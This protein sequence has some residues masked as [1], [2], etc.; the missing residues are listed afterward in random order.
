MGL[1]LGDM[2]AWARERLATVEDGAPLPS[3]DASLIEFAL[4]ISP[5][6][7]DLRRARDHGSTAL[8]GGATPDQ[9]HSV[10][11]LVSGAGV[12]SVMEGSPLVQDLRG[13]ATS[14]EDFDGERAELWA[15]YIGDRPV[16]R[17]VEQSNPGFLKA[18][19]QQS[20]DGFRNFCE[21][22]RLPWKERRL[23]PR[24]IELICMALDGLPSHRYG[25]G[26]RLHL[27]NALVAG[28]TKRQILETIELAAV[29]RVV[30]GVE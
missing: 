28:A 15:R 13:G 30:P 8:A 18:L 9:L 19:V 22:M 12:H 5:F 3:V 7:L 14:G 4:S 29:E 23:S 26:F 2:H 6:C 1:S 17:A 16:W 11:T 27:D 20:P 21:S 10:V 25:P 24:L